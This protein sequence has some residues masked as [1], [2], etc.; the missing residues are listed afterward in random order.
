MTKHSDITFTWKKFNDLSV[1]EL[2]EILSL[3]ESI[4]AIE[5]QCLYSDLDFKDQN[6]M[7]LQIAQ[8]K[9]L[10]AYA[11]LFL[12]KDCVH[13]GRVA[14]VKTHRGQGLGKQLVRHIISYCEQHHLNLPIEISAQA[15][16]AAF[17]ANFGFK[18][19]S[20]PY[21]DDGILHIN[22]LRTCRY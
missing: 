5:Q 6:A 2:Y 9:Q 19:I 15:H 20:N 1:F 18:T 7:H 8:N 11:R 22:M 14:T 17:Y 12:K 13:F 16:L 3:R 10:V 4:F 21:D